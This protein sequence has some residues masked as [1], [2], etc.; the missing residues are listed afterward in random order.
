MKR[1]RGVPGKRRAPTAARIAPLRV[2]DFDDLG[3]EL[4][5]DHPG[6]GGGDAVTDLDNGK[7]GERAGARHRNASSA[8]RPGAWV[9]AR[10]AAVIADKYSKRTAAR[11][12]RQP[13]PWFP[14]EAASKIDR[15]SVG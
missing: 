3:A 5:E 10:S 11:E 15:K 7:A 1:G 9:Q 6:I 2:L 13:K 8:I 4:A 12:T 14:G